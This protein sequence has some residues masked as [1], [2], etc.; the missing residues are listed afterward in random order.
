MSVDGRWFWAVS[1]LK[2]LPKRGAA[3]SRR[4]SAKIFKLE[5]PFQARKVP[6]GTLGTRHF[7]RKMPQKRPK[8]EEKR[9]K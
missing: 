7:R 5:G 1:N 6:P 8:H 2:I 9:K 4:G 3:L